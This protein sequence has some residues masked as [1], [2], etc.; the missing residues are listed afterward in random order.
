MGRAR[1]MKTLFF[2]YCNGH[3]MYLPTIEAA[4]DGGYG[5]D[6]QMSWVALGSGEH[7]MN[8]AL[9]HLFEMRGRLNLRRLP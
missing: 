3:N 6:A 5:A 2:G 4:A 1:G 8:Q 9:I 7:M